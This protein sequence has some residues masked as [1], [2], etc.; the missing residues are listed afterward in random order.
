LNA[1]EHYKEGL[2]RA[3]Q[4][5]MKRDVEASIHHFEE[6]MAMGQADACYFLGR[7][8]T[9]GDGVIKDEIR[10][11]DY[12]YQGHQF[13][14]AKSTYALGVALTHGIGVETDQE[15]AVALFKLSY[16]LLLD[17]ARNGDAASMYL[18]GTVHY[19]GYGVKA[20]LLKALEWF[21][22]SADLGYSDAIYMLAMIMEKHEGDQEQVLDLYQKAAMMGHAY[23]LYALGARM[24]EQ[25]IWPKAVVYLEQAAKNHY[26]LAQYTLGIYYHDHESKKPLKAYRWFLEAAKQGHAQAAYHV[27]LYHQTG[28]GVQKDDAQAL[29]WYDKAAR[30]KDKNALYHLALMMI[31]QENSDFKVI[32][33]LLEQAAVQDHP[34]AQYNLGVMYQRGDGVEA[35]DR[36][37]FLWYEKSA[38]SGLA[39]AQ[40]NLGMFYYMGIGVDQNEDEAIKWWR[41]AADQGQED[42]KKLILSIDNYGKLQNS[43]FES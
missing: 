40:Y 23:A 10:A 41:K 16:P 29:Y 28:K 11:Y 43:P 32:F 18:V 31:K 33:K 39:K 12:H 24:L 21:K 4:D 13:K 7:F 38:Q 35:N 36:K 15:E 5:V 26:V 9:L 27:G 6:A 19:Y 2:K 34:H 25:K 14:S 37:A 22:H 17:E 1:Q 30:K 3:L 20:D 42:A 8:Y